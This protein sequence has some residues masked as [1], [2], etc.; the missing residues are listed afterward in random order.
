M[1]LSLAPFDLTRPTNAAISSWRE[2]EEED[3]D[4]DD[5]QEEEDDR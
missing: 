3:D 5:G 1:S 2:E 4:D